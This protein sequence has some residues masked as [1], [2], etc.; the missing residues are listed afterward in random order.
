MRRAGLLLILYLLAASLLGAAS[1][2]LTVESSPGEEYEERLQSN[3]ERLLF[4]RMDAEA[5]L[6]AH[7]DESLTLTLDSEEGSLSFSLP[8]QATELEAVLRAG[9]MWDAL[10]LIT[11]PDGGRLSYP[12][13]YGFMIEGLEEPREG[14]EYWVV[15]RAM[16]RR[17]SVA[18][19]RVVEGDE[20]AI[21][22]VQTSGTRLLP[23]MGLERMG[24]LSFGLYGSLS[25]AGNP[26]VEALVRQR[27]P[28]YPMEAH[29]GIGYSLRESFSVRLGLGAALPL[30]HLLGTG[31]TVARI[32]SLEG[33][34]DLGAGWADRL[35]LSA[36]ARIGLSCR[37]SSWTLTAL[38]GTV[39]AATGDA[40][41]NRGL[42]FTL[43]TAYTYTP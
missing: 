28:I 41:V 26:G 40:V 32:L 11:L 37:L 43:G 25:A 2:S 24:N 10:P 21:L 19:M 31:S 12:L 42:F 30:T 29:W 38:V 8:S 14:L 39:H 15:D 33:W 1:L 27:L 7:L 34:A 6:T 13:P 36:S 9:L 17:G 4:P 3:L 20:P 18:L 16:K 22:A 35:L 5:T 23:H